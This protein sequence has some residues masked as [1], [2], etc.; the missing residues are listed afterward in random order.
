MNPSPFSTVPS[1]SL[2]LSTIVLL[3]FRNEAEPINAHAALLLRTNPR[4][5]RIAQTGEDQGCDPTSNQTTRVA[6]ARNIL[7]ATRMSTTPTT[8]QGATMTRITLLIL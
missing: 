2:K 8:A 7:V 5:I 6:P 4:T 3:G 1:M